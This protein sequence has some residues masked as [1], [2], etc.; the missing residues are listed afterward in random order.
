[1]IANRSRRVTSHA[2]CKTVCWASATSASGILGRPMTHR[3]MRNPAI[4][5][6]GNPVLSAL[7]GKRTLLTYR[8]MPNYRALLPSG[9]VYSH[10]PRYGLYPDSGPGVDLRSAPG[11]VC[12][13]RPSASGAFAVAVL[14]VAASLA[15]SGRPL[16]CRNEKI[17][18]IY[19]AERLC[20]HDNQPTQQETNGNNSKVYQEY[21]V[22]R[23]RERL[24]HA[25]A[26]LK[27]GVQPYCE[28]ILYLDTHRRVKILR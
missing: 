3:C 26:D 7:P 5:T 12:D 8:C 15:L 20:T 19:Y 23:L 14:F 28:V 22:Q 24:D 4:Q 21:D 2:T 25:F 17:R 16:S 1:M 9:L 6:E 13:A 18:E 10:R 11:I 27:V